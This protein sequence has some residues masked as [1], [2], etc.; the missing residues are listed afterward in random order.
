MRLDSLDYPIHLVRLL[1]DC[2]TADSV[3]GQVKL[4][5]ALHM[6]DTQILVGRA[7]IDAEQQLLGINGLRQCAQ[8]LHLR[9]AADEPAVGSVAGALYIVIGSGIFDAFV[10]CHSD[11]RGEIRLYLHALLGSHE[12]ALTVNMRREIHTLLLYAAEL[13]KRKDLKSARVGKHGSVPIEKLMY[14]AEVV[15]ELIARADMQMICV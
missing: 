8:A 4:C 13:G 2:E 7:L 6:V 5:D 14:S 12:Y 3:S 1:A 10:K 9:L 11:S 15:N